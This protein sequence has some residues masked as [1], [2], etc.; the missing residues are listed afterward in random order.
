[1]QQPGEP[2]TCASKWPGCSP[3][4]CAALPAPHQTA[5]W[6][7]LFHL[8][9]P[10]SLPP[11][12]LPFAAHCLFDGKGKR[13]KFG[14]GLYGAVGILNFDTDSESQ[15]EEIRVRVCAAG[16]C[17]LPAKLACQIVD[18]GQCQRHLGPVQ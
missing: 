12:C 4:H 15:Y 13:S 7:P 2:R 10:A 16:G 1:M 5:P 11:S 3:V 18:W 9:L 8:C 17:P 6:R 14:V